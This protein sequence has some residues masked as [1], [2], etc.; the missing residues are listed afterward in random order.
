MCAHIRLFF[1]DELF[2]FFTEAS[3][4]CIINWI[5]KLLHQIASPNC[6]TKLPHQIASP[7]CITKFH[8][9]R[10]SPNCI[11]KFHHQCASLN[12]ITILH[13]QIASSNGILRMTMMILTLSCT[14]PSPLPVELLLQSVCWIRS[15]QRWVPNKSVHYVLYSQFIC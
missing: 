4:N 1:K 6:F 9:Q 2:F 3:P 10:A 8:H 13:H 7:H 15:C 14:W 12:C 11:T 5:P